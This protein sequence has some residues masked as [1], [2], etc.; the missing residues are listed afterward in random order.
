MRFYELQKCLIDKSDIV[1]AVQMNRLESLLNLYAKMLSRKA[2]VVCQ[3]KTLSISSPPKPS[4][5]IKLTLDNTDSSDM[6]SAKILVIELVR[7]Q[8]G[9]TTRRGITDSLNMHS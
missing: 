7:N 3:V 8:V 5:K 2:S 6:F 4:F 9:M 1:E